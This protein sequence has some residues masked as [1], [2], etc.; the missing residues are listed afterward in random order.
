M[1]KFKSENFSRVVCVECREVSFIKPGIIFNKLNC[2]CVKK[3]EEKE[4]SLPVK[5]ELDYVNTQKFIVIG[6]FKDGDYEVS[7][8]NDLSYTWRIPKKSFENTFKVVPDV[9]F[10]NTP[11]NST[12]CEYNISLENIKGML[13]EDI[14]DKYTVKELRILAK[15]VKIKGYSNM[16]EVKLIERLL[17]KAK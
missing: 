8:G 2:K 17:A 6:M 1:S 9:P 12:I 11:K 4:I 7:N 16:G 15:A 5:K 13:F 3:L 14:K 10:E